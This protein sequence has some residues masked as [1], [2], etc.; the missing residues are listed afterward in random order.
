MAPQMI[1]PS[2]RVAVIDLLGLGANIGL[3]SALTRNLHYAL[4]G[5]Q[6]FLRFAADQGSLLPIFCLI[7]I[8]SRVTLVEYV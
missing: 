3:A 5:K 1:A 7:D 2:S 4:C 8:A 6:W